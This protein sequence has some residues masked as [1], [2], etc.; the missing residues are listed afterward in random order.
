MIGLAGLENLTLSIVVPVLNE[1]RRLADLVA[2]LNEV[3]AEQIVIVDGGSDDGTLQ[4]L[5]KHCHA[6]NTELVLLQ[7]PKGRASQMNHGAAVCSGDVLV[8]LHADTKLPKN[9]KQDILLA[10]RRQVLWGRF[11]ISFTTNSFVMSAIAFFINMRSRLTAIAT[12]DQAIFIDTNLFKLIGGFA[13]IP[14]M[15]DVVICKQLKKHCQPYCS[16]M[17]ALTS[18]R[19]WQNNGVIKTVLKMWF[20]RAAFFLGMSAERLARSYHNIR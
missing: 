16:K 4:W 2:N 9:A 8:F 20:Y 13:E 17:K 6:V 15:E 10:R 19:R 3:G 14:L 1:Q 11:D 5:E 7:A 18:A 12:G